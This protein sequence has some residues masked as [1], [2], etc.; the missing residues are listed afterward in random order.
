LSKDSSSAGLIKS[1]I[2]QN[3]VDTCEVKSWHQFGLKKK[4][5]CKKGRLVK[6]REALAKENLRKGIF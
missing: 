4:Y 3:E 1:L 5:C 6:D 2:N